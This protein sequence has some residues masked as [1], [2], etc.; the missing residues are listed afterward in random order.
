V[1][2]IDKRKKQGWPLIRSRLHPQSQQLHKNPVIWGVASRSTRTRHASTYLADRLV[3]KISL[4]MVHI[5]AAAMFF[6]LGIWQLWELS[7][8]A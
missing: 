1:L 5:I 2:P 3:T 7:S 6:L 4:R 8:R